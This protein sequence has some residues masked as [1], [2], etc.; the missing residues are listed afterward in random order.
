MN[1][2]IEPE[3][4]TIFN[5]Y[6]NYVVFWLVFFSFITLMKLVYDMYFNADIPFEKNN[7]LKENKDNVILEEL[8]GITFILL[9]SLCF[10]VAKDTSS[11]LLYLC[12]GPLF[13]VTAYFVLFKKDTDWKKIALTSSVMCKSFYVIFVGIFWYLGYMMPIYCYSVWIMSDQIRLA[14]WKNNA[15]RSR[16]LFEDW[17][18]PRLGYPLFL[19]IPFFD[20]SFY[21]REFFMG[22][23][24]VI[25]IAWAS[26]IYRL[27][28][29][30]TF[31]VQPKIEGFG[32]DIVYLQ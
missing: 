6:S 15:D 24:S 30:G 16:R 7:K 5:Q 11:K 32:R 3:V 27:V 20:T 21:Q 13:F 23:S 22:V 29:N 8:P 18:F 1:N 9:H 28:Q 25:L 12:W 26:G 19:L 10:Y 14:W 31:F 4:F 2:I 17:F